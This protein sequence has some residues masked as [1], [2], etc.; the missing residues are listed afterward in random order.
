MKRVLVCVL[1]FLLMAP[2]VLHSERTVSKSVWVW[3]AEKMITEWDEVKPFLIENG[4]TDVYVHWN[5]SLGKDE[6]RFFI[7]ELD[8]IGISA[9]ALMGSPYWGL[10]AYQSHI[11]KRI[12]MVVSYNNEVSVEN[13][14]EGIHFDIEPYL[15]DE[16]DRDRGTVITE[17]KENVVY[18]TDYAKSHGFK[19]G[20]A[21]PFW[22]D[23][24]GVTDVDPT[25]YK[26][27]IDHH[28]SVSLMSYR[29]RA[30]GSNSITSLSLNEVT[31]AKDSKVEIGIELLPS[32]LSYITFYEEADAYM[33]EEIGKVR[34]CFE[35][36]EGWKGIAYHD[37]FYWMER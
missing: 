19:T 3:D 2:G 37:L 35:G 22:L 4:V 31:Y 7:G 23:H 5:P 1:L 21:I 26:T 24:A 18:Y 11:K 12:D 27:M 14:F 6:Y 33:E 15:L 9:H 20:A 8:G 32:S 36:E 25:F 16:W 30:L 17:W 13:Q 29:D 10:E 28:D 34:S